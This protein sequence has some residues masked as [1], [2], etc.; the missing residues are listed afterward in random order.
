MGRPDQSYRARESEFTAKQSVSY[1][2]GTGQLCTYDE[3]A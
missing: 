3:L 2:Q 1:D